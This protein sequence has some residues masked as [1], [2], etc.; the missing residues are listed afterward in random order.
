MFISAL[1]QAQGTFQNLDFELATLHRNAGKT[2][3]LPGLNN[4]K[5]IAGGGDFSLVSFRGGPLL[6]GVNNAA[7]YFGLWAS[8]KNF[9]I[10]AWNSRNTSFFQALGDPLRA[11]FENASFLL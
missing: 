6:A 1:A 2:N 5:F 9:G 8:G 10:A 4:V 7:R 3:V 11:C